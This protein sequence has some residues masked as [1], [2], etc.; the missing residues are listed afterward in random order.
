MLKKQDVISAQKAILVMARKEQQYFDQLPVNAK[1]SFVDIAH[2][3]AIEMDVEY[4]HGKYLRAVQNL[5]E[6]IVLRQ[7]QIAAW[8]ETF[9]AQPA[10]ALKWSSDVFDQ[11]ADLDVCQLMLVQLVS[12]G[13]EGLVEEAQK[14]ALQGARYPSRSTSVTANLIET[15]VVSAFAKFAEDFRY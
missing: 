11:A 5:E 6:R 4:C 15:E 14:R 2:D 3:Q 1:P 12:S 13:P 10:Y 8:T 7:R 9:V